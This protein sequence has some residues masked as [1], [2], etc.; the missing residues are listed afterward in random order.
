VTNG[1]N[2]NY[3]DKHDKDVTKGSSFMTECREVD[4]ATWNRKPAFD[5]FANSPQ[6]AWGVTVRLQVT[7]AKKLCQQHGWS[8]FHA[9][10][11][12]LQLTANQYEPIRYRIRTKARQSDDDND[13]TQQQQQK[14]VVMDK[15]HIDS[16]VLRRDGETFGFV[17]FP[18]SHSFATFR[19]TATQAI[20]AFH[21]SQGLED[22]A[23]EDTMYGTV[24]PWIDFTSFEHAMPGP[25]ISVNHSIP[26]F[27]FG[28]VVADSNSNTGQSPSY[29]QAFCL[30]VHH[31]LMD[32]LHMGRF[33][34]LYQT[35]LDNA[36]HLLQT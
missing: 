22:M 30:H 25:K 15:I 10:L 36:E 18:A 9:S 19:Q 21:Q 13:T 2:D 3:N 24:L 20:D 31:G 28:K 16:T 5:F 1:V 7:N 12:L 4:V 23:G 11:F 6:P 33:L 8:Y 26:R 27:V 32:G 35:N 17:L 29:S 14:V 34:E